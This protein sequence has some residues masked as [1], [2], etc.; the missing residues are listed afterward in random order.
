MV[1]VVVVVVVDVLVVV[2]LAEVVVVLLLLRNVSAVTRAT[3]KPGSARNNLRLL[4]KLFVNILSKFR[5]TRRFGQI[6]LP[7][8]RHDG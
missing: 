3:E 4:P 7:R 5:P 8:H 1:V 2:V 6:P